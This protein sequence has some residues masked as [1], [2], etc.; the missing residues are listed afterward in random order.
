LPD[1]AVPS[2]Q[3]ALSPW[4][5]CS[6]LQGCTA[7]SFFYLPVLLLPEIV[8]SITPSMRLNMDTMTALQ[9]DFQSGFMFVLGCVYAYLV[10]WAI[11]FVRRKRKR[12]SPQKV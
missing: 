11:I 1:F 10:A 12:G 9:F 8:Y 6:G 3:Q 2:V 5:P 4:Y 7:A